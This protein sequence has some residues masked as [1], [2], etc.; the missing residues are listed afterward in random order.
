M[1]I[2]CSTVQR[3][4]T[5]KT[6]WVPFRPEI[7]WQDRAHTATVA[8]IEAEC[9]A[10]GV[11]GLLLVYSHANHYH[12]SGPLGAF[13]KR[14]SVTTHRS[15]HRPNL[16][17]SSVVL[18]D[19]PDE[20]LMQ[21]A[22]GMGRSALCAI[23]LPTFSLLGWAIETGAKDLLTGWVTPDTR[24]DEQMKLL[25]YIKIAGNNGWHDSYAEI[26]VPPMLAELQDAGLELDLVWGVMMAR[27]ASASGIKKLKRLAK[28]A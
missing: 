2:T 14:H 4:S 1:A 27:G 25:E 26:V 3:R 12:D 13:A 16:P 19:R 9:A 20:T 21:T 7:G 5:T 15:S 10:R 23:E 8:W 18:V 11:Q 24:T 28:K 17:R 6:A 22:I